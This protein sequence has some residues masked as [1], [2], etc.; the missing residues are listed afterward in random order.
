METSTLPQINSLDDL[1]RELYKVF[2]EDE[3]NVEYVKY[4]MTS[5]KSNPQD[6]KKFA[7]FDR[8]K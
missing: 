3:V 7:K 1:I 2:E 8:Y 6:W 5:Y 4:L